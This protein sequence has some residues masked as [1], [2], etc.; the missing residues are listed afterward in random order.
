[1]RPSGNE[2]QPEAGDQEDAWTPF[3]PQIQS[4]SRPRS[5][6]IRP[7]QPELLSSS[8]GIQGLD[9]ECFPS[10]AQGGYHSGHG[11]RLGNF[12]RLAPPPAPNQISRPELRIITEGPMLRFACPYYKRS[13][14]EEPEQRSCVYP[15]FKNIARLK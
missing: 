15:G 5:A 4:L 7:E 3:Q 11:I 8:S 9:H 13:P 12:D 1:M 10:A 14:N 6:T 2:G